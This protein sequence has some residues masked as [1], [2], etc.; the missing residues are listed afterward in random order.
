MT[1]RRQ[2][3]LS[4]SWGWRNL[5]GLLFPLYIYINVHTY[6][7]SKH[8]HRE[9]WPHW[10]LRTS[11]KPCALL[12]SKSKAMIRKGPSGLEMEKSEGWIIP[13][14]TQNGWKHN[15][16]WVYV[17]I[18]QVLWSPVSSFSGLTWKR[19]V[20][21]ESHYIIQVF[22]LFGAI[23]NDLRQSL[24]DLVLPRLHRDVGVQAQPMLGRRQGLCTAARAREPLPWDIP[25]AAGHLWFCAFRVAITRQ[26]LL[27]KSQV[28]NFCLLCP[29]I[30]WFA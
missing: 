1:N 13:Q 19:H 18:T 28:C 15:S 14:E 22:P 29:G 12:R 6:M 17:F 24:A 5:L 20:G 10:E 11:V 8:A 16:C 30:L 25:K 26:L 21:R 27:Q 7:H 2:K 9:L 4:F 23:C 3:M